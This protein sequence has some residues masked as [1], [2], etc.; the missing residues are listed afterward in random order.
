MREIFE[1]SPADIGMDIEDA[2]EAVQSGMPSET[3]MQTYN[4]NRTISGRREIGKTVESCLSR[5]T[6]G[7]CAVY[8]I[9][10]GAKT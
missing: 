3:A 1:E 2:R 5:I 6:S 9:N 4:L 10:H 8:P 7:Q